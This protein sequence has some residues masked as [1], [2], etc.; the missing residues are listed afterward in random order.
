MAHEG[1]PDT[2]LDILQ[3]GID[4][5]LAY[6]NATLFHWFGGEPLLRVDTIQWGL[7]YIKEHAPEGHR[8]EHMITTNGVLLHRDLDW[9]LANKIKIMLSV[10][11]SFEAQRNY[12]K[13]FGNEQ[14]TYDR[15]FKTIELLQQEKIPYFCNMVITPETVEE[16]VPNVSYMRSRGVG[17]VQVA[18][19]L[20]ANWVPDARKRYIEN[21][22]R[23][24][25]E[26]HNPKAG[27][28]VQ[29]GGANEPVLGSAFFVVDCNGDMFQGCAVVL[30]KTLP[31]FNEV[32]RL[33]HISEIDTLVGRQRDPV[34]QVT[35]FLRGTKPNQQDWIRLR[36]NM[37]LGYQVK[38]LLNRLGH[39][40]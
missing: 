22:E 18:Y 8:V 2:P 7:D 19:E 40:T 29:N 34:G 32:A 5:L 37:H 17:Q 30:E 35:Y 16:M 36:S 23:V 38:Q 26:F 27:F 20:G 33:G 39:N 11:G 21:L 12:R 13:A 3:K 25:R 4:L 10:D 15:I 9:L 14:G 6:S 24:V 1:I 31:T 28:V